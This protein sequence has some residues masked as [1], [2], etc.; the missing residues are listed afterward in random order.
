MQF[1]GRPFEAE[2]WVVLGEYQRA[3]DALRT[4]S[5]RP[6]THAGFDARW[7]MLGRVRLLRGLA[8]EKLG[9]KQE[10]A[11]EYRAVLAQWRNADP[12]LAPFRRQA[13]EGLARTSGI[14]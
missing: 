1:D 11:Q 3:V 8:L 13:E 9:R 4:S 6:W 7:G 5:R 2:V 12:I 14:G 10:A